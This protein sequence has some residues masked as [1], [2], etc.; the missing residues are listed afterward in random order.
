MHALFQHTFVR[1]GSCVA[2]IGVMRFSVRSFGCALFLLHK[3]ANIKSF[4]KRGGVLYKE[5]LTFCSKI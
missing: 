1:V 2:A 3:A 5:N 4:G